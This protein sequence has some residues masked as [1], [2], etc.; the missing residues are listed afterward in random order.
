MNEFFAN[1]PAVAVLLLGGLI[2]IACALAST[3]AWIGYKH[4]MMAFARI[5]G[6]ERMNLLQHQDIRKL[7]REVDGRLI[8]VETLIING[9]SKGSG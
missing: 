5:E 7:L 6:D 3:F 1:H 9:A 2:S 4:I 8:R